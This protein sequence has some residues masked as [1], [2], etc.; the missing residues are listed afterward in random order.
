MLSLGKANTG[1]D[2]KGRKEGTIKQGTTITIKQGTTIKIRVEN[3]LEHHF[4]SCMG[5]AQKTISRFERMN[6][7]CIKQGYVKH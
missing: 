7:L 6:L 3:E 4:R 1:L 2:S 5:N